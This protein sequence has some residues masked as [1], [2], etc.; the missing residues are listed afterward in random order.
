MKR[1]MT[2]KKERKPRKRQNAAFAAEEIIQEAVLGAF[3]LLT[4]AQLAK[5]L[6]VGITTV[7]KWRGMGCPCVFIG[8]R[9][10]GCGSRP[11]YDLAEVRKWLLSSAAR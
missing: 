6:G 2:R 5:A 8:T 11:R 4:P 10:A 3:G 1:M 9:T 7:R